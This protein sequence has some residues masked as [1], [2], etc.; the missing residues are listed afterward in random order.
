M[1]VLRLRDVAAVTGVADVDIALAVTAA[2][3]ALGF[4]LWWAAFAVLELARLRR[5]EGVPAHPGWWG[6]VFPVG[7]MTLSTMLI[8]SATGVAAVQVLGLIAFVGLVLLW[9]RVAWSTRPR[10]ES[11][12]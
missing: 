9:A 8:G 3:M 7:A 11:Q 10:R 6:F 1:V 12:A 2:V 5:D 4:G